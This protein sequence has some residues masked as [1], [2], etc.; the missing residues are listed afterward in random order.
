MLHGH[1]HGNY[2]GL[3]KYRVRDV[4]FDATGTVVSLLDDIVS[5]ALTG[6]IRQ[7]GWKNAPWWKRIFRKQ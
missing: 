5:D 4:G 7:H 3:E 1:L 2:S 6:K